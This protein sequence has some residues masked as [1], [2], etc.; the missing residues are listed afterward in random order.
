MNYLID[1]KVIYDPLNGS[2]KLT[3]ERQSE[4]VSL[5]TIANKI[6]LFLIS[7][8]GQLVSRNTL[9]DEIWEKE[10]SVASSNTLNQYISLLRKTFANYFG[11]ME[12]IITVPRAGYTF[13]SEVKVRQ[14]KKKIEVI[15]RKNYVISFF[16]ALLMIGIS[17]PVINQISVIN[18]ITPRKI[19]ELKGCPVY[20]LSGVKSDVADN[21]E[22]EV[23]KEALEMNNQICTETTSFYIYAEEAIHLHKPARVLFSRCI[24]WNDNRDTCQNIYYY[25]WRR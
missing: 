8:H 18:D 15:R 12:V 5:T 10:G 24:E 2:L 21:S 9:F 16:I 25:S 6:L 14:Y 13:N 19:G 22:Y 23:A 3:N 17:I 7:H 20:D 1:D 11:E 4:A